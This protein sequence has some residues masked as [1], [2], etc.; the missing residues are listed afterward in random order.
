MNPQYSQR[1]SLASARSWS[2]M[3]LVVSPANHGHVIDR[4][5]ELSWHTLGTTVVA[6]QGQ[7]KS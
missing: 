3:S 5:R 7:V 4:V 1:S 6:R 2:A